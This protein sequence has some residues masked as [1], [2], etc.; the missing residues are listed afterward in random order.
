[1]ARH[2]FVKIKSEIGGSLIEDLVIV[3]QAGGKI[4]V[5]WDKKQ[6]LVHVHLLGRT[7]KVKRAYTFAVS[8]VRSLE[9]LNSD[10]D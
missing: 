6:P 4:E 2:D 1:M 9:V 10:D 7:G 8:A 5:E 3:D